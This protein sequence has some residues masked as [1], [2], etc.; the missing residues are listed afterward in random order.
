MGQFGN[1][2]S[3]IILKKGGT[4]GDVYANHL[5]KRDG[6]GKVFVDPKSGAIS[7]EAVD[8]FKLGSILPKHG[9]E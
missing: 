8:E 1:L 7:V 2:D 6:N 3:R 9:M 5:I 4:I